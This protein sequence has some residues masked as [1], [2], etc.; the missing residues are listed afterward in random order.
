MCFEMA[1]AGLVVV[2]LVVLFGPVLIKPIEQ[3]VKVFF[4]CVKATPP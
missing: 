4:L 2:F 3:N 1:L